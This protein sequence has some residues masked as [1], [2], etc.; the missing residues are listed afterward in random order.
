MLGHS[1]CRVEVTKQ[2][3]QMERGLKM[4]ACWGERAPVRGM[5]S[6][7]RVEERGL[8]RDLQKTLVSVD[9]LKYLVFDALM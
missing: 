6:L 7:R 9:S 8:K 4:N 5:M 2:V 3:S 1:D